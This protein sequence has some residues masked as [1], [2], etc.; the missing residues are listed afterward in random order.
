MTSGRG[1][2]VPKPRDFPKGPAVALDAV[3]PPA[4]PFLDAQKWGKNRWG[5]PRP[6]LFSQSVGIGFDATQPLNQKIL[7]ASDL[8]QV[9]RPASAVAL[10]K[11]Q[12]NLFS[13]TNYLL[14]WEARG[15]SIAKTAKPLSPRAVR[16]SPADLRTDYEGPAGQRYFSGNRVSPLQASDWTNRGPGEPR[17]RFHPPAGGRLR[18][19][20]PHSGGS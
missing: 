17:R 11:G 4:A 5:D 2:C 10:L 19:Q 12:I 14:L 16:R 8:G 9:S 1:L 20:P 3:M 7:R 13:A 15:F 18:G 6:P